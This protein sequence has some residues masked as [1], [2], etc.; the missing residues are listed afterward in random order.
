MTCTLN[1]RGFLTASAAMA[2]AF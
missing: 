1:R 2:A